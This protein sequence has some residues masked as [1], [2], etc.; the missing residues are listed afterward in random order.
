[1]FGKSFMAVRYL[2]GVQYLMSGINWWYKILPFPSVH[3]PASAAQKHQI[4]VAM[5]ATGWMFG[6]TKAI[7]ILTGLS[8]VLNRFVPLM[9]VVSMTV[10]VTT[11]LLDAIFPEVITGWIG[12]TVSAHE[13]VANLLDAV[14][15]GGAVLTMQVFL[16]LGYL[17]V[18]R[19]MLAARADARFP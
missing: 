17:H 7:E 13:L 12:G 6:A 9:L 16:M 3:D 10:A 19:P 8:L 1:M 5:I 18:Y 2:L 14:Y 11:F 4:A 15:W